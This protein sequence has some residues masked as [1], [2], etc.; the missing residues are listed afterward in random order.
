MERDEEAE[1]VKD[2]VMEIDRV[3]VGVGGGVIVGVSV[4]VGDGSSVLLCDAEKEDDSDIVC[5]E[6]RLVLR[7]WERVTDC[8]N[9]NVG[10]GGGVMVAVVESV[11]DIELL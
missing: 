6:L 1:T 10:V 11:V 2:V 5:D 9:E 8:V 4:A 7:D 3:Y